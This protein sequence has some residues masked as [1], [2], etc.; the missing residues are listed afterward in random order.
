MATEWLA[1]CLCRADVEDLLDEHLPATRH[2]DRLVA[3]YQP[4]GEQAYR[5]G[6]AQ[7]IL[8]LDRAQ[9]PGPSLLVLIR[10]PIHR[11]RL[12]AGDHAAE[13]QANRQWRTRVMTRALAL[14]LTTC[15]C[16]SS[17]PITSSP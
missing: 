2:D 4:F 6:R 9:A 5:R 17:V 11:P 13:D 14:E 8:P 16:S 10:S 7:P 12:R 3:V 15:C 1:P